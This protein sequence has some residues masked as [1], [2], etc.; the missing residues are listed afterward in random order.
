MDVS[1][2]SEAPTLTVKDKMMQETRAKIKKVLNKYFQGRDYENENVKLWKDY[3]MEELTDFLKLNYKEYGFII[4][5]IIIKKGDI[6]SNCNSISRGDTD[7]DLVEFLDAKTMYTEIRINL[8]KIYNN[9]TNYLDSC[10]EKLVMEMN[11]MLNSKLEGKQ[12]SY[13]LAKG[14][15]D[16][17]VN[18]LENYLLIPNPRPCSYHICSILSK[19]CIYQ[20]DYK[21]VNLKYIP[22]ISCYSNDSLYCLLILF[23]LDN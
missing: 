23:I 9:Q 6:R 12:Y 8:N 14:K 21:I 3:A 7:F 22:L 18:E 13:D 17:I 11:K 15:T 16:E 10:N 20:F 1:N 19:P 2:L 4:Y 5:I